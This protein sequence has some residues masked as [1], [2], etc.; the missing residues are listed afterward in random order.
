MSKRISRKSLS[1]DQRKT[2][3]EKEWCKQNSDQYRKSSRKSIE[4]SNQQNLEKHSMVLRDRSTSSAN[5]RVINVSTIDTSQ[6]PKIHITTGIPI[7][8]P[9]PTKFNPNLD[10]NDWILDMEN[11]ICL[12]N[13]S[14]R[15]RSV[16]LAFLTSAVREKINERTLSLDEDSAANQ[17]K[18]RLINLYARPGKTTSDYVKEF[19]QRTQMTNENVRMFCADLES[20]CQRAFPDTLNLEQYIIGQFIEGVANR[21]CKTHLRINV[22]NSVKEMVEIAT[23]YEN[24]HIKDKYNDRDTSASRGRYQTTQPSTSSQQQPQPRQSLNNPNIGNY[25]KTRAAMQSQNTEGHQ[26]ALRDRSAN[27]P[28]DRY[29]ANAQR[30]PRPCYHCQATDHVIRDCP[31]RPAAK[32][33]YANNQQVQQAAINNV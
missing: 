20:L 3:A 9:S 5:T 2:A 25:D 31:T 11:Y 18:E 27:Q 29:D 1:E 32:S 13:A 8:V 16:Y 10:V 7:N 21:Q 22:P 24:A 30:T 26:Y 17:I 6:Q 15:K 33:S 12:V 14:S 4:P 28:P 19:N 23:K